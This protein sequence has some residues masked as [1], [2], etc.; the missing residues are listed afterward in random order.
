MHS[1]ELILRHSRAGI[2]L[3]CWSISPKSPSRSGGTKGGMRVHMP[4]PV[5]ASAPHLPPPPSEGKKC[6]NQTK[7]AFF[8][9]LDTHFVPSMLPQIFWCRN[10]FLVKHFENIVCLY[11]GTSHKTIK[12]LFESILDSKMCKSFKETDKTK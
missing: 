2:T 10:C 5:D 4:L 9:F 12:M 8:K 6:K 7:L 1:Q 11:F 3:S